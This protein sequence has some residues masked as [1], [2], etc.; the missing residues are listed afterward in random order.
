MKWIR[1]RSSRTV[2]VV[3]MTI[4][5]AAAPMV[6]APLAA[7]QEPGGL[8]AAAAIESAFVKAIEQAEPSVVSIARD[9]VR[10]RRPSEL[11]EEL[12]PLRPGLRPENPGIADPNYIPN[13]FGA[14]II[15]RED[16][17]ILTNYHLVRGGPV[18][19]KPAPNEQTLYVRLSDK[20]GFA[21]RI[22]AADPR[23]DLAVLKIDANNLRPMK[24]GNAA[25]IKKGQMV[26]ALGNPYAIAR[27]GSASATWG[28]IS[29][30]SRA[31]APD[32][33]ARD[34]DTL[35]ENARKETIHHL[36][37]LLQLD[38]RLNLGTSGGP[39]L[40]LRGE[41]IGITTSLAA[42]AGYEKSAGFAV[43]ID[44]AMLRIIETLKKGEEVEYGFLGVQFPPRVA[45]DLSR[46]DSLLIAER[47]H[48][49]G[50]VKVYQVVFNSAAA[51]GGVINN[52][53][54]L[55]VNGKPVAGR[56]DLTREIGLIAPGG[57]A[58]LH[59]WRGTDRSDLTLDVVV[60][61]WPVQDEEG[62][63]ST[64]RRFEPWR[65]LVVDF[66]TARHQFLPLG[67][68]GLEI[69]DAVLVTELE[70]GAPASLSELQP[71]DFITHVNQHKVYTP[72]RFYDIVRGFKREDVTLTVAGG[73]RGPRKVVVKAP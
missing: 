9:K 17:L 44:D 12:F 13:E 29:N 11:E 30:V 65:G 33:E 32:N 43:P 27:D 6:F 24:L 8:A 52:D 16:G 7:G 60:G 73:L 23:S 37:T 69:P 34:A 45:M 47:F 66:P 10:V 51:Q 5:G 19:G 39:L 67:F 40:N 18:E 28:I 71:G 46:E 3:A 15:V 70:S 42:I 20:Q 38:M 48:Q 54:I 72:Q 59:V 22:R 57:I 36:G 14:G 64:R 49:Q 1:A 31:A 61:K 55:T 4:M 63:I 2:S 62:I 41:V 68:R 25:G 35:K 50:A 21:A 53:L 58:R 56:A 26:L